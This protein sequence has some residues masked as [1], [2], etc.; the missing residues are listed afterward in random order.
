MRVMISCGEPSGD[1]YAAGLTEALRARVPAIDV[2]GFGG[3]RFEAAGGRLIGDFAGVSVTGLTEAIRVIPRSYAMLR[4]LVAAA[5]TLRPD[6]FVALDFP[7][8]NF[9]LMAAIH[10]LGIPVVYYI[11]PQLWAWRAGR[12]GAMKRHVDRVLVIFPFEEDLYRAAGVPVEFVG[13]PLVEQPAASESRQVFLQRVGLHPGL[14]TVALLPG[15]RHN[16]VA[17]TIPTLAAALP[18][19]LSRVGD[20]Q[21][22]VACAHELPDGVFDRLRAAIMPGAA[23]PLRLVR[24]ETDNV[25]ANTDVAITAS[26]TATVQCAL[27]ERPM[28]VVYRVSSLT[29]QLAKRIVRV[30]HIAMPNLVAGRGI[31]PELVQDEFTP[32]RVTEETVTLLQDPQK[33]AAARAALRDVRQRLGGSGASGRA[34]DAV[35]AVANR[36]RGVESRD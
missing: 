14:P 27:H 30:D 6:V 4:R 35:I 5:R 12:M 24:D 10:T 20:V 21:F 2:F 8:F 26:G 19:I 36:N 18:M 34:A 7:D 3:R 16:E 15:S 25:L 29:Y 28:V 17:R 9:R 22:V 11:S 32:E 33:H 23:A 31:V 1:L 13:H